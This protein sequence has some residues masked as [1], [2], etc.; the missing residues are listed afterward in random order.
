MMHNWLDRLIY[1]WLARRGM[2]LLPMG[3]I[4]IVVAYGT[5]TFEVTEEGTT[6]SVW[7]PPGHQRIAI[8][9]TVLRRTNP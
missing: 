4:G 9:H 6:Y 1:R 2:L 5:G 7:L 3:F 8:N